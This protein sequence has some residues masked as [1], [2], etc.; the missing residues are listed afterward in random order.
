[1]TPALPKSIYQTQLWHRFFKPNSETK[2]WVGMIDRVKKWY[3]GE[4]PF[5]FPFPKETEKEHGHGLERDALLTYIRVE[6]ER[7][8]YLHDLGLCR[9]SFLGLKVGDIGSGPFPTLLVF[10]GCER[11]CIDPLL[12]AYRWFGFPF[13]EFESEIHYINAR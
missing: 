8:T 2:H 13:E 1:M 7:A 10:D 5:V 3:S 4:E 12:D 11:Y 9:N 6:T